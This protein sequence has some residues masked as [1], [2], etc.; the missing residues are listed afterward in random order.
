M[1]LTATHG[2][3]AMKGSGKTYRAMWQA[4]EMLDAGGQIVAIDPTGAWWG[5]RL[6]RFG[7]DVRYPHLL[8]LGAGGSLPLSDSMGEAVARLVVNQ[9]LSV[10]LDLSNMPKAGMRRFVTAFLLELYRINPGRPLHT[11]VDEAD[12]FAPEGAKG[13]ASHCT[14]AMADYFRRGRRKGLGGTLI[15]QRVQAIAKDVLW[16][17]EA[18]TLLRLKGTHDIKAIKEW[19]DSNGFDAKA[20]AAHLPKLERGDRYFCEGDTAEFFSRQHK[21]FQRQTFDSS[22]TPEP[23]DDAFT[24]P[25]LDDKAMDAIKSQLGEAV[26]EIEANDPTKLK[27]EVAKLRK[28]LA[29]KPKVQAAAAPEREVV[30]VPVFGEQEVRA[31]NQV[32]SFLAK[33]AEAFD[34]LRETVEAGKLNIDKLIERV[35]ERLRT[36]FTAPPLKVNPKLPPPTKPRTPERTAAYDVEAATVPADLAVSSLDDLPKGERITLIA[37]GQC[38][39]GATRSQLTLLTGYRKSTRNRTLQYLQQRGLA[40]PR[41]DDVWFPTGGGKYLLRNVEPLPTGA[42]L[43]KHFLDTL[44]KGEAEILRVT[45]D[46]WPQAVDRDSISET[47]GYQKS[48]RNRTIQYL[49]ARE[50]VT[51]DKAGVKAADFLFEEGE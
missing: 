17:C 29:D 35:H 20:I 28:Q 14:G 47:T 19:L 8:V 38:R 1:K 39:E 2:I 34:G 18:M 33:Q 9:R 41:Q 44:P 4:E 26:A 49:Q 22:R 21:M 32:L 45:I 40:Q 16:Q 37:I 11:F 23:G 13:E 50:L 5:L 10:V 12:L 27:A 30:K 25:A 36:E 48:T 24:P 7:K 31:L 6:D 51:A 46:A 42:A 15:T 3:I 43:R